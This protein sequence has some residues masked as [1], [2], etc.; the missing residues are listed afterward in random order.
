M[1]TLEIPDKKIVINFPEKV[2]ELS[3][4]QAVFFMNQVMLYQAGTIDLSEFKIRIVYHLLGMKQSWKYAAMLPEQKEQV[5]TNIYRLSEVIDSF[6]IPGKDSKGNDTKVIDWNTTKNLLP[7]IGKFYGPADALLNLTFYE[8]KEAHS[9][10]MQYY[11]T[12]DENFL[13][14]LIA[15]LYR[16][17][18]R[19]LFILKYLPKYDG[20]IR[21]KFSP[22]TNP[23]Y[24]AKRTAEITKISPAEKQI[25]VLY[26]G[27]CLNFISTG[28]INIDGKEID[29]SILFKK[30][31]EEG[32]KSDI[33]MAGLLFTLAESKVFGNIDETADVNLYTV[34]ARLYQLKMD[35]EELKRKYDKN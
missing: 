28:K 19:F 6:F 18:K 10:Y 12:K 20:D 17:K 2:D 11:E 15:I 5:W 8:Y 21:R 24:L 35:S 13:N 25:V 22:K 23:E 31:S 14:E 27:N 29:L 4:E 32:S 16:Q 33:G 30:G 3:P 34:L 26:F 7:V 1:H 9:C